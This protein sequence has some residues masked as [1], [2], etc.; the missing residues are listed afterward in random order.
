TSHH[1]DLGSVGR[2]PT[3]LYILMPEADAPRLQPLVAWL[4]ADLL[5]ELIEQADRVGAGCPVRMYLD[6][7]RQFGYLPGLSEALPTLRER[8]ISVLLGV[9]V[10]SQIE[11][12][13][14]PAEARTLLGNTETKLLFRAG[15]L[16]TARMISAWLG[17]TTVQAVSVTTRGRDRSTT[18]YPYVRPLMPPEELT[19][20]PDGAVIA[21]AGA[22]PP[23]ALRQA[24]YCAVGGRTVAPPPSP[25]RR[26]ALRPRA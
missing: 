4:I 15:D 26:R 22:A 25:P 3:A 7:F 21:L 9:Q 19:R 1:F 8:G 20:I 18:V 2:E 10:L 6:E 11:E 5:D 17:R 14:G 12:I 23:L 24:R 13:Y 16:E